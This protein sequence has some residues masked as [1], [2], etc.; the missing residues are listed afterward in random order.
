MCILRRTN[1]VARMALQSQSAFFLSTVYSEEGGICKSYF[2]ISFH[3]FLPLL[4]RSSY[5]SDLLF[6]F[7]DFRKRKSV[8]AA[9]EG[10]PQKEATREGIS[11]DT[12]EGERRFERR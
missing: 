8:A 10:T 1:F 6:L 3:S 12:D 11:F 7:T 2:S 4:I 5:Y 9:D